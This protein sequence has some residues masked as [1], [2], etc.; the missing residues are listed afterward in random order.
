M[1]EKDGRTIEKTLEI[2]ASPE[3]VWKAL[4]DAKELV[5]WFPLKAEAE[6][7]VGG[8]IWMSWEGEFEG[9][10]KIEIFEPQRHLR[11]TWSPMTKD[12]RRSTELSVDYHLEARSGGTV[13]RLV[14]SGFGRGAAWDD[15]Y[16]G[17]DTGW[18]FELRS[19]RLY[20]EHHLG[21]DRHAIFLVGPKTGLSDP[22]VW[23]RVLRDGFEAP[24]LEGL[25]EG[26][27]YSFPVG[28]G[29]TFSGRVLDYQP[30][31]QF[32]GT[33]DQLENGIFRIEVFAAQPHLWLGSWRGEPSAVDRF[34]EPWRQMLDRLF[35]KKM[36]QPAAQSSN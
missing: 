7:R 8:R 9:E 31:K 27:P 15:E 35:L 33:V 24:E 30:Q 12:D 11:T 1:T 17:I 4:T 22:E 20:L 10:H 16:D 25:S 26:D 29:Q 19:L 2:G 5:R 28:D 18:T 14:H 34:R 3:A 23:N 32:A 6:P 36:P 13:L 21:R